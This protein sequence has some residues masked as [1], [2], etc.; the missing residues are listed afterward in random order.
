MVKW[1]LIDHRN[2]SWYPG[3]KQSYSIRDDITAAYIT[4]ITGYA[5]CSGGALVPHCR[6]GS[7][8]K[9]CLCPYHFQRTLAVTSYMTRAMPRVNNFCIKNIKK[10]LRSKS[11][12]SFCKAIPK[13]LGCCCNAWPKS[14]IYNINNN[15]KLAWP[16][17]LGCGCKVVS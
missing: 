4:G 9:R 14:N 1:S 5:G 2:M 7:A 10:K 12:R 15:I 13:N 17:N 6:N 3:A 16:K 8:I 11:I